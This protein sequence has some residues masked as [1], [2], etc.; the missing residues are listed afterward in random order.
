M[1]VIATIN[2][3]PDLAR[4]YE[5]DWQVIPNL[6]MDVVVPPLLRVMNVYAA[7][8][9]YT[10]LSFVLI[11]SGTLMLHRQLFGRWS[12]LPLIA[13]P[14]LYNNVF[15][16]GTMNYVFG[17]GLALWALASW[18]A[19]RERNLALR[20]GVSTLFI[21]GLFFCHLFAVGVY[22]VGL[23]SFELHRLW[24][25]FGTARRA[26]PGASTGITLARLLFDF[27]ITGLPFLPVLPLL[28]MSPT[29]GLRQT[30]SWELPGKLAGLGYIIEVYSHGAAFF[31]TAPSALPTGWAPP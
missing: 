19:L 28:M 2:T 22:G 5:I 21:L 24:T 27:A 8:Q 20:L 18:I 10:I 17:M 13:F 7:G 1:Q 12:V 23:L 11:A 29:W 25:R 3:D 6:M 4:F 31:S 30:Y 9:L 15:L 26:A 16:V 14:L